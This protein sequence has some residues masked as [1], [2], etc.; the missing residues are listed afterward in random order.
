MPGAERIITVDEPLTAPKSLSPTSA[1]TWQQCELK[2]ALSYLFGWQEPSTLPQLVGNTVHRAAELLYGNSSDD[3]SRETASQLLREAIAEEL[4]KDTYTTL[5]ETTDS[6]EE[7]VAAAG[8]DALDGL[9]ALEDPRYITVGPEGLEVWVSAELYGA[10]VRGRVDRLYDAQGAQVIADYKTGKV[11]PSRF[12]EK[13]F[14]GLWT[15]AAAL[16]ASDPS[17]RLADRVE[18]LYLIG[19]ERLSRP[20]L[21]DVALEHAKTLARIWRHITS[22]TETR[23]LTARTSKLCDWCAFQPGC[24]ARNSKPLPS[25]GTAEHDAV[26]RTAGL[27]RRTGAAVAQLLDRPGSPDEGASA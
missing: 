26:L 19:R 25:I 23:R 24:P 9:F 4:D 17:K 8:E 16:A 12:T 20:V 5:R 13:S 18:L 7:L 14:F 2:Y 3:R 15:Y 21:R 27:T 10:P 22:Q 1:S 11:P 6:V